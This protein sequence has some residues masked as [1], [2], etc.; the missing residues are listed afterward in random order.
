MP[1]A[2]A[3]ATPPRLSALGRILAAPRRRGLAWGEGR[4]PGSDRGFLDRL[5][6]NAPLR[7]PEPRPLDV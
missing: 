1:A 4:P 2:A 7:P 6:E 5:Q 3:G